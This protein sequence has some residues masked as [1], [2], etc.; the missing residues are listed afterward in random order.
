MAQRITVEMLKRIIKTLNETN[1]LPTEPHDSAAKQ[2]SPNA[3]NLHLERANNYYSLVQMAREGSGERSL[4]GGMT[5]RELEIFLRGMMAQMYIEREVRDLCTNND[6]P[7]ENRRK[8][9]DNT[10]D[11]YPC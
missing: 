2:Y 11:H 3:L 8:S 5:K 6:R 4:S 10:C 7:C 9:D 1:G